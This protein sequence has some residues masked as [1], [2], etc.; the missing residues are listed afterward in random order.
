[1]IIKLINYAIYD[2]EIKGRIELLNYL[3]TLKLSRICNNIIIAN[4]EER[5]ETFWEH[6]AN[7]LWD[8]IGYSL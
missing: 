5:K 4:R 6:I 7:W 8:E 2:E 3:C 1:M